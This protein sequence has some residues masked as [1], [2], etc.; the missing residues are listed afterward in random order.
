MDTIAQLE[1]NTSAFYAEF[2]NEGVYI[3]QGDII[4]PQK[5]QEIPA[6][7]PF[8]LNG[9]QLSTTC[10]LV[11]YSS[12]KD[13]P[14]AE[15]DFL[16]KILGAVKLDF[17]AVSWLNIALFPKLKWEDLKSIKAQKFIV[18]GISQDFFPKP[19]SLSVLHTVESKQLF[20]SE[21]L[22]KVEAN[23]ELK[24]PLWEALQKMYL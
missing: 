19:M 3:L 1:E 17:K 16:I 7:E 10:V 12:S 13:I 4:V 18:F 21:E 2:F 9:E 15:K 11:N 6:K 14:Q 5:P 24:A 23:R 22:K 8:T 20:I